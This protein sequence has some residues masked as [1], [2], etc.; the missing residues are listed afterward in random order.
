MDGYALR[1]ED[2]FGADE[3]RFVELRIIGSVKAGDNPTFEIKKGEACEI[4]TGAPI[5]L[6][7]N[8]VVMEEYT[9]R[10]E[11]KV[12]II[13]PVYPGENIMSAGGDIKRG[14]L[15]LRRGQRITPREIGL[16]A[17]I[18]KKKIKVYRR[19]KVGIIS[20]GQELED[21]GKPL[22]FGKI[23]DI[24]SYTL[25]GS[26]KELDCE[27]ILYGVVKDDEEDMI[28]RIKE[29][30]NSCD[31][32]LT[33]G[34]T[35]AGKGDL[36]YRV[37]ES[38]GN[39]LAHGL[40]VKPGKP[41]VIALVEGKPV[42]GLPGYPTS[43][44]MIFNLIV[45]PLIFHL[46][47]QELENPS[48]VKAKVAKRIECGKGRREL[49]PVHVVS[50]L[51][52]LSVYEVGLG[53]GAISSLALADGYIDVP[54]GTQYLDEGEE[55]TVHLFGSRLKLA[56]LVFIGS[57]DIALDYL[58]SLLSKRLPSFNPK[59]I[60]TGSLGGLM[61]I[62][63]GEADLAGIH[64]IDEET[65]EYNLPY[66]KK[67]SLQKDV[68]LIRGYIREQGLILQKGNPKGIKGLEDLLRE[69]VKMLNR[70]KG[71][72]TRILFDLKLKELAEKKGMKFDELISRIKGYDYEVKAHNPLAIA[73]KEGKVDVGIGISTVA[74]I[75]DLDFI[76]LAEEYYDFVILKDRMEKKVI[77]EFLDILK[78][79]EIMVPGIKKDK[80]TGEILSN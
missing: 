64:L 67:Y 30:V 43:A 37:L 32:V 9:F 56:D 80:L 34:S 35:S 68:Y 42:I 33:S 71:S 23:Y 55:V 25:A 58:L 79:E 65:K 29:A 77:R 41:T 8:A 52:G 53:S 1:A 59:V 11:D 20:T 72:G 63:R 12:R 61:A 48:L 62:K 60:N 51:K 44:L 18:G 2:T 66:I 10:K 13:R 26:L 19:L 24:N 21:I 14:E 54:Q 5:P 47:N 73:V 70:N 74:I 31:I 49:L 39:L 69:D 36:I 28:K 7:A 38:L 57:H 3:E 15:I 27:P 16:L 6:G 4:S 40:N 50:T 78:R 45:K 17:A 22:S 76:P 46:L 75:Y